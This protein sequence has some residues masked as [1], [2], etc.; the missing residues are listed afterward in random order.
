MVDKESIKAMARAM[1]DENG[2]VNCDHRFTELR[3]KMDSIGRPM[4]GHQ[5]T[6]CGRNATRWLPKTNELKAAAASLPAWD[7]ELQFSC[8]A[9]FHEVSLELRDEKKELEK[10]KWR[11]TYEAHLRS[12]KWQE[13]RQKVFKR[14]NGMCQGCAEKQGA[15]VHHATYK[16]LGNELLTDLVLYCAD[17]HER[18]HG[19]EQ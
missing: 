8:Y 11:S 2:Y 15:H 18:F 13:L 10:Q 17:C 5:C 7:S 1:A 9:L 14:E 3:V 12:D 16:R 6:A 19:Q 4:F